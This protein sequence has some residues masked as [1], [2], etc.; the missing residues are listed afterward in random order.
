[1]S[2][3][4]TMTGIFGFLGGGYKL[5]TVDGRGVSCPGNLL[6]LIGV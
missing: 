5:V 2:F 3:G 1:L 6:S 4:T